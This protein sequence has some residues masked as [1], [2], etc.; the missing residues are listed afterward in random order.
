MGVGPHNGIQFD[1]CP[2]GVG[3]E[4]PVAELETGEQ[5]PLCSGVEG[6]TPNDQSSSR[7]QLVSSINGVSSQTAAPTRGS[8]RWVMACCQSGS[9]PMASQMAAVTWGLERAVTKKETLRSR[10]A[11]RNPSVH[12][13][14][15]ARTTTV[16][17]ALSASSPS[18]WPVTISGQLGD[19][20]VE[21][22]YMVGHGVGAGVPR[23]EQARHTVVRKEWFSF[24][25]TKRR[26]CSNRTWS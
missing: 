19:G 5:A 17:L 20:L 2:F 15:S 25:S 23:A 26:A 10:Q 22:G 6:L 24:S 13:A 7:G 1:R 8:P 16:R 4:A 14:E 11:K 21:E 12:P 3:V 9:M 18:R